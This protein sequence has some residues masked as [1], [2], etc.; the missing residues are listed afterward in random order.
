[1]EVVTGPARPATRARRPLSPIPRSAWTCRPPRGTP[2][3]ADEVAGR[4]RL[5]SR[6]ER[7]DRETCSSSPVALALE[8]RVPRCTRN[9]NSRR[10][11]EFVHLRRGR[12]DHR[13]SLE[14]AGDPVLH[15]VA[16]KG[17]REFDWRG[18]EE[19]LT[20]AIELSPSGADSYDRYG[21]LCT[22]VGRYDEAMALQKQ[23]H[24]LDPLAHWSWIPN[25]TA[26]LGQL[27]QAY[28]RASRP[29]DVRSNGLV[30]LDRSTRR[31]LQRVPLPSHSRGA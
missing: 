3:V 15:F 19:E 7:S 14:H 24:E 25:T 8:E 20:R 2:V 31:M 17:L 21:R 18:A 9:D 29:F 1:M 27:G 22:A 13:R 16:V 6:Q 28:A 10:R 12:I 11:R 23:A 5:S 26:R 4:Q 30:P